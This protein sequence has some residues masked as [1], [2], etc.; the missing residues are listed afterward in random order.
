MKQTCNTLENGGLKMNSALNTYDKEESPADR[1]GKINREVLRYFDS[2]IRILLQKVNPDSLANIEEIRLRAGRPLMAGNFKGDWFVDKNSRLVKTNM[3]SYIVTPDDIMYTLGN[4]SENSIYAYQD[5]I[6]NGFLTLSGGHRVGLA[7]KA[8]Y[9]GTTIKNLRDISGLNIRISKE[10]RGCSA[11]ILKS[12]I[13]GGSIY[14]TLVISPPQCGKTTIIR[15][16]ARIL[17]DGEIFG[18]KGLK[19]GIVDERSEIAACYRGIPQNDVGIRTDVIDGCSKAEGMLMM[20]RSMSPEIIITDE[21]GSRG[22]RDAVLQ[23]LNSGVR[24]IATAHGINISELKMRREILEMMEEKVFER[25]VVLNNSK[26]PGTVAE[27]LDGLSMKPVK[28]G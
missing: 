14:N 21:I 7:G 2:N 12:L 22:D 9:E 17:S 3:N 18:L 25:Y 19:V 5:E 26:G 15:D 10:F 16:M 11:S 20:L 13:N 4:M 1:A 8:V 24:I 6:R 28:Q 27:I 23:V